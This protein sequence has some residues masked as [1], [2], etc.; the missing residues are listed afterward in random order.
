MRR[1]RT[2]ALLALALLAAP[3]AVPFAAAW[4]EGATCGCSQR[5]CCCAPDR[6]AAAR[7]RG[8]HGGANRSAAPGTPRWRCNHTAPALFIAADPAVLAACDVVPWT[9]PADNA[10]PVGDGGPR[11]GFVRID[12]PPPWSLQAHA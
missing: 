3:Q 12:P 10:R 8:C 2:A 5:V 9:P 4:R 1:C 6:K 7:E 11:A